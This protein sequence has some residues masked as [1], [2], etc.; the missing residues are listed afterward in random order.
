MGKV[1]LALV[2]SVLAGCAT[3]YIPNTNVEDT[4]ENRKVV[5]FCE[6]YR[7]AMEDKNVG[8]LLAMASPHYHD[9]HGTPIGDDDT[10]YDSLKS[11]LTDELLKT[12]E[13]RYEIKYEKVTFAENSHIYVDYKYS[14]SYRVPKLG[15]G[16]EWHHTVSD[17]RLDLLPDGDSYKILAGM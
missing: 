8:K 4:S 13:I 2:V 1:W 6:A 12:T 9:D 16:N 7:H 3:I 10:D 14:A 15:G 11:V 17:N 5:Q